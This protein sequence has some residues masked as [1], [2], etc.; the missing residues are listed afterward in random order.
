[1]VRLSTSHEVSYST[2]NCW[3]EYA[4]YMDIPLN[5]AC[6]VALDWKNREEKMLVV[7]IV[8]D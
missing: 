2:Y 3:F 7:F 5:R 4:K 1:M 8:I 6:D